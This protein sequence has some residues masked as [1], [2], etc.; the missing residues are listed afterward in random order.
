MI[1]WPEVFTDENFRYGRDDEDLACAQGLMGW[2]NCMCGNKPPEEFGKGMIKIYNVLRV[3]SV[4][5]FSY[6]TFVFP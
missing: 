2:A 1:E 3:T 5:H 4:Y 6:A